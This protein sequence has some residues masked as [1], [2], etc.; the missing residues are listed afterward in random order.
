MT[1]ALQWWAIHIS[2]VRI[3]NWDA[4]QRLALQLEIS[5]LIYQLGG[6]DS[7]RPGIWSE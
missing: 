3:R 6:A 4:E 5:N 2:K 1:L 7:F